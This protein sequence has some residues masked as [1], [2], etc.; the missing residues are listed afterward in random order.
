MSWLSSRLRP[1]PVV[2]CAGIFSTLC[3]CGG[4]RREP[5]TI[6]LEGKEQSDA[7]IYM[8]LEDGTV[9]TY[10]TT[11]TDGSAPGIYTVQV[12]RPMG[13][14]V[15]L[16]AGGKSQ[17]LQ[18]GPDGIA[19]IGGGYLLRAPVQRGRSWHGEGGDV[20]VVEV[21][22]EISVPAG[23]FTGCI[24]T[25]ERGAASARAIEA[26]YC[27]RVGMVSLDVEERNGAHRVASLK[28]HGARVDVVPRNQSHRPEE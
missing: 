16:K 9:F 12:L 14:R 10:E 6:R 17:H 18:V 8:P 28:S 7:E 3:A 19:F 25:V 26:V 11:S 4:A 1:A 13:N 15:N 22:R 21:G 24:R 2:A 5:D 23:K 27:P 20:Q